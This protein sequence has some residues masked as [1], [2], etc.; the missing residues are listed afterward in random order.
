MRLSI[1][2]LLI[3]VSHSSGTAADPC[4]ELCEYDRKVQAS[5]SEGS[6]TTV[7]G[8][9]HRY[10][11]IDSWGTKFCYQE[12]DGRNSCPPSGRG[13]RP[14]E[15]AGLIDWHC[16]F[17]TTALL[18]T[19]DIA[20]PTTTT[21]P[22]STQPTAPQLAWY[23]G[24]PADP[25]IMYRYPRQ[26]YDDLVRSEGR[27]SNS[28]TRFR[29]SP[30][31]AEFDPPV[32]WSGDSSDS[33]S[34]ADEVS[35][36]AT[37]TTSTTAEA[38]PPG[39]DMWGLWDAPTDPLDAPDG[40]AAAPA[41][42][43]VNIVDDW[44]EPQG[45]LAWGRSL[46]LRILTGVLRVL[47][48]WPFA[49]TASV[50]PAASLQERV[51]RICLSVRLAGRNSGGTA[52]A[53]TV[54]R[55]A[56]FAA[57]VPRLAG[58]PHH[59]KAGIFRVDFY[60]EEGVGE[61]VLRDWF[62]EVARQVYI[63]EYRLVVL[64]EDEP[65]YTQIDPTA[66]IRDP[67]TT[68]RFRAIGRFLALSFLH[69]NPVGI[70]F[71]VMFFAKLMGEELSLD[72]IQR[73]EP[74]LHRSLSQLL[75]MRDDE[76]ARLEIEMDFKSETVAVSESNRDELIRRRVNSLMNETTELHFALIRDAFLDVIPLDSL[77]AVL[78]PSELRDVIV[79]NPVIDVED[80]LAHIALDGYSQD[81]PQIQW[82]WALLRSYDQ[83]A[84]AA[85]VRF[86]TG[87]AQVPIGGIART[88]DI[89]VQRTHADSSF[90]PMSH[91]CMRQLDLPLYPDEATLRAKVTQAI[92]A[93]G[94][95]GFA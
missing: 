60:M 43:F 85:F 36:P 77:R 4:V 22:L 94:G 29:S 3:G 75:P 18:L 5:C 51:K 32:V 33:D 74:A 34:D 19:P 83:T 86:V 8:F 65:R 46:P 12:P 52:L 50:P 54:P 11:H 2:L 62:T 72:D 38:F 90:L 39:M 49:A 73:D 42:G 89:T 44:P 82:L 10:I 88:G 92:Q 41:R 27:R 26:S 56:A 35:E 71:P 66:N 28:P 31:S 78:T 17:Y 53:F 40:P 91:T 69:K 20:P 9:C 70:S 25:E 93:D 13:V 64:R 59:V 87:N 80:L 15:V 58:P 68:A 21:P 45:W 48:R 84:L 23:L 47:I 24:R 1:T 95:M 16:D 79:G 14:H 63:P 30:S 57:S 37:S 7:D 61:G 55:A 6:F 76:L 81:S 67:E